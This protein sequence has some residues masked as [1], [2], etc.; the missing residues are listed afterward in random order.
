LF[1]LSEVVWSPAAERSFTDFA[2]R[3]PWHLDRLTA[4]G[5]RYRTPDVIGLERDRLTTDDHYRLALSAPVRG[6]IRLTRDGS[7]PTA[8]SP[9][10]DKPIELDLENGPVTVTARVFLPDGRPGPS[11]SARFEQVGLRPPALVSAALEPGLRVELFELRR[12]RGVSDLDRGEVVRR[13][14]TE[15]VEL[16]SWTPE[17]N[18]GL[19]FRGYLLVPEDGVYT[20]RLT[21][22]DGAVLRF[23][24]ITVLDHDGLHGASARVGD[25]ALSAGFHPM[26]VRY[27][28]AGGATALRLE[29]SADGIDFQPVDA[30]QVSRVIR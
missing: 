14:E 24:N 29:W 8:D 27:V 22:D 16:P 2:R 9:A 1:A 11:R 15:S 12:V 13:E 10:Y 25:V 26:E 5:I 20:F 17:E 30:S 3:L 4:E 28:Q 7:E 18:F 21:S 6:T 23:A 19:R